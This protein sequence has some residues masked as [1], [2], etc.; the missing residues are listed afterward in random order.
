MSKTSNI[1]I[2]ENLEEKFEIYVKLSFFLG[3]KFAL[4][5]TTRVNNF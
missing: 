4:L 5:K 2:I 1:L 3:N